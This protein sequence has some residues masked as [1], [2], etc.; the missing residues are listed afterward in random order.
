MVAVVHFTPG[1]LDSG[2][3]RRHGTVAYKPLAC[4]E[5]PCQVSALYVAPGGRIAV[6]PKPVDQLLLVVNGKLEA[7]CPHVRLDPMAGVGLLLSAG[8]HCALSSRTGAIAVVV[9]A[10]QLVADPC[11]ISSPQRVMGTQ[12][13]IFES[14]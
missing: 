8:E 13:P 4:G 14:N 9:E 11:G 10:G 5:G 1:A 6:E 12:W 3:V 2:N 7:S